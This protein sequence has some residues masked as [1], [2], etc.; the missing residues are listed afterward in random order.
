MLEHATLEDD[1]R[2]I[3]VHIPM[4]FKRRGGRKEIILPPGVQQPKSYSALQLALGRAFRWQKMLDSGEVNSI[5]DL[6]RHVGKDK[7]YV[8]RILR[9][10]LLA[11]DI[12]EMI[13]VGDEP[14]KLSLVRLM[15]S[16]PVVWEEQRTMFGVRSAL[17]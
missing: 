17:S 16:F 9:L 6:A 13:L 14:E 12:V 5:G 8:G 15:E 1:G 2:I 3:H 11:P 10:V 4:K 7:C